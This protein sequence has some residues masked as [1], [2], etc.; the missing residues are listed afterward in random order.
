MYGVVASHRVPCT[1]HLVESCYFFDNGNVIPKNERTYIF[2][3]L[4]KFQNFGMLTYLVSLL[5]RIMT[6]L[7]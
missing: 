4:V 6:L 3:H 5:V 2:P 7:K 1:V